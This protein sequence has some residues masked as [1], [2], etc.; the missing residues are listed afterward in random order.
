MEPKRDLTDDLGFALLSGALE[1]VQLHFLGRVASFYPR[2]T[3]DHSTLSEEQKSTAYAAAVKEVYGLR[4]GPTRTPIY[5]VLGLLCI[6][7]PPRRTEYLRIAR[8][9]IGTARVPVDAG[10]V[11]G[12][13]ALS[14]A[15]STKPGFDLEYAGMLYDAGGDVNHR[16]RPPWMTC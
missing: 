10:D 11:S 8:F 9:L 1:L 5:N 12:T 7:N 16:N 13:T 15:F 2:G 3:S 14:H 4:W 6:L